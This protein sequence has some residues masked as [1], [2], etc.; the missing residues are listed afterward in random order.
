MKNL[1][2]ILILS[3][4]FS[5]PNWARGTNNQT[6]NEQ[7]DSD[8]KRDKES[9]RKDSGLEEIALNPRG[10]EF[11][12]NN[13]LS[14]VYH[15]MAHALIDFMDLPVYGQQE[16]AA[17]VFSVIMV[18]AM[19][20][21]NEALRINRGAALGF[22]FDYLA[23]VKKGREWDWADEHGP[24]MQRYYNVVCL[25]YG[26]DPK[27]RKD[28]AKEMK[29]P[30]HRAEFCKE[31]YELAVHAWKPVI[32]RLHARAKGHDIH[33]QQSV[34]TDLQIKA[35]ELIEREVIAF[36]R[37]YQLP[38]KLRISIKRCGRDRQ[39]YAFYASGRKK[40]TICTNY[41]DDLY[42]DGQK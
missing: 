37:N 35:A 13:I 20:S 33:I 32:D 31:E 23:R 26:A 25:T 38:A 4:V 42:R 22:E 2:L 34:R 18:E 8:R 5:G 36:N 28:F 19:Y 12:R 15:E 39:F 17:D 16:D 7:K 1:V 40:I 11:M 24:D 14:T 29:L 41:I 9:L 3:L 6:E 27:A 30:D 10:F 21:D